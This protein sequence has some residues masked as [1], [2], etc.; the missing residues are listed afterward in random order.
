MEIASLVKVDG[1]KVKVFPW[2]LSGVIFLYRTLLEIAVAQWFGTLNSMDPWHK[3]FTRETL[4]KCNLFFNQTSLD[5]R[6]FN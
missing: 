1:N 4:L 6:I 5:I 2:L 3:W